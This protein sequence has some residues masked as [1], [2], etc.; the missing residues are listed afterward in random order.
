MTRGGLR[1]RAADEEKW[2]HGLTARLLDSSDRSC[3]EGEL[4]LYYDQPT[5]SPCTISIRTRFRSVKER[6]GTKLDSTSL[7]TDAFRGSVI[8][9]STHPEL[10][11][12]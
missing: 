6:S 9:H 5:L 10:G 4:F 8:G 11:F 7:S 1:A 3:E 2:Y 12:E